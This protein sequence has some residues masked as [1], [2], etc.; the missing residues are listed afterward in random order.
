MNKFRSFLIMGTALATGAFFLFLTACE[1][2]NGDETVRQVSIQV[3]G[4]YSSSSGIASRQSGQTITSLNIS[5]SGDQLDAIDNLGA[6]WTG[7]IG[8]ADSSLATVNLKGLTSTG[9][10]VVITGNI[11]ID[12]TSGTLS[13]SW[14]EP[15]I[16]SDVYAQATVAAQPTSTPIITPTDSV[17]ST[18]VSTAIATVTPTPIP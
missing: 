17:T 5:Q 10:Q 1:I 4:I 11:S 18:P 13:G 6:R 9:E 7:T 3:A 14:I 16:R 8:Q 2:S 12:G 15:V